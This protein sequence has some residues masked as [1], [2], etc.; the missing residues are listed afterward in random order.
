MVNLDDML[1]SCSSGLAQRGL[2][3]G[4]GEGGGA[5]VLQGRDVVQ[6]SLSRYQCL[7][8]VGEAPVTGLEQRCVSVTIAVV[9][10]TT[11]CY[12]AHYQRFNTIRCRPDSQNK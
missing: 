12:E 5:G 4:T 1:E 9:H 2:G 10:I 8:D 11:L 3:R 7:A 6:A